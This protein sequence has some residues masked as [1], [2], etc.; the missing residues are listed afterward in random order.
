M[1]N[2][3]GIRFGTFAIKSIKFQEC[4]KFRNIQVSMQSMSFYLNEMENGFSLSQNISK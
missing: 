3:F 4:S 2:T 1:K